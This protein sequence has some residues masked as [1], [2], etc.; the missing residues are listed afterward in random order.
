MKNRVQRQLIYRVM[1]NDEILSANIAPLSVTR[2]L[3][4]WQFSHDSWRG[5]SLQGRS[6]RVKNTMLTLSSLI[7]RNTDAIRGLVHRN[8]G[9]GLIGWLIKVTSAVLFHCKPS[10]ARQVG[11][12]CSRLRFLMRTQ[13]EKGTTLYLKSCQVLLQQS[14]AGYK[15]SDITELKS[16]VKRTKAGLPIIIPAEVRKRIRAKDV[17][18][19][20]LWM[21]LFGWYRICQF[22]GM[23]SLSTITDPGKHLSNA[24]LE[25]WETFLEKQFVPTLALLMK[26]KKVELS[27]PQPFPISKSSPNTIGEIRDNQGRLI[28][29]SH[30]STS[31]YSLV[32][33]GKQWVGS[34]LFPIL[35][36]FLTK[37]AKRDGQ[38][39]HPMMERIGWA[40]SNEWHFQD[41]K[42]MIKEG[43]SVKR[44]EFGVHGLAKLGFKIE[45]AGKIRVFA[46]VDAFTQWVMKP[47]HDSIFSILRKIPMDGTFDQTRPVERLGWLPSFN[48]WYYSIDLS[49]ATDRL[50]VRLQIP[51]MG[52]VLKWGGLPEPFEAAQE[53]A[54]LLV[55]R[56]YK[57]A[58][59]PKTEFDLPEDLP[60]S[61]TYSVGQ[62]MGALSSWA[63][64]AL[65][66]HAIVHWAALRAYKLG[67]PVKL[68]FTEYAI[69]GDDIVIANRDVAVQYIQI[70]KQIGVKAG[71]AKSIVSKGQFVVEFAKKYFTP[72]GRADM[73]PMKECIATYSS[74]LLVCEFVK[75]HGLSLTRILTFLGY[76]YKAKSRAVTALFSNLPRRLRVLLIWMR[77]PKGCFP[78]SSRDWLLSSGWTSK[79]DVPEDPTH[80]VWW[81][82]FEAIKSECNYQIARY[83]KAAN[84]YKEAIESTGALREPMKPFEGKPLSYHP[85]HLTEVTEVDPSSNQVFKS[86]ISFKHLIA[87]IDWEVHDETKG[88][89]GLSWFL[90]LNLN[91]SHLSKSVDR[92]P[93]V[94][95][96]RSLREHDLGKS[97]MEINHSTDSYFTKCYRALDWLFSYD[98]IASEIPVDYWPTHRVS[99]RPIREFLMV[100]KWFDAFQKPFYHDRWGFKPRQSPSSLDSGNTPIVS[101]QDI[102]TE[103]RLFDTYT[104][105]DE[106]LSPPRYVHVDPN[107]EFVWQQ[108]LGF[109]DLTGYR[110]YDYID[111]VWRNIYSIPQTHG[112]VSL[113]SRKDIPK[114]YLPLPEWKLGR[115]V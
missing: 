29:R 88:A 47:I 96:P 26:S 8:M 114:K 38:K 57:I 105:A 37:W 43:L 32:R 92:E 5:A 70:L 54:D 115:K 11:R 40:A 10:T 79:W 24:L 33:A 95:L 76:G 113:R 74:T 84:K 100:V 111:T 27:Q 67:R 66:H 19:I 60:E 64:L 87:P 9:R 12:F 20:R 108:P 53:W 52:H 49:A 94:Q 69:L 90:R 99:D 23:L 97:F 63:M 3:S 31:F 59:P 36:S 85:S 30:V 22:R 35:R 55:K 14:I 21:T 102:V 78:L 103:S 15:V 101:P 16:R 91:Y 104:E 4:I 42:E 107:W 45:A 51:L 41:S 58:L 80:M 65:T 77:S 72:S 18:S 86:K 106:V 34:D 110:W 109:N 56:A 93:V 61:V 98:D 2:H 44:G 68:L 112:Q 71:L 25:E 89:E 39:F 81:F 73:L 1:W 7:G 62:P 82:V 13:G 83:Y 6:Q 50:P 17:H 75:I 48:R 46:M 28:E